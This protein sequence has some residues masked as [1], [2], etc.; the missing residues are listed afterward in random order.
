MSTIC[1][2]GAASDRIDKEYIKD[3]EELGKEMARRGHKMIYGAGSS[4]LMGAAARGMDS[5][6]GHIIGVT[7]HFMHTFEPIYECTTLINTNTMSERKS[8]MEQYGEAFIIVPGGIG[9][10][11]EFFQILTLKELKQTDK[12]I[13]I[14]NVNGYFDKLQELLTDGIQKG[15][16]RKVVPE[17]YYITDNPQKA[18]DIIES[19]LQKNKERN[20]LDQKNKSSQSHDLFD[21]LEM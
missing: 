21:D 3:V 5:K 4:G 11:D 15:F 7:P 17:L 19:E 6:N 16:I 1:L 14:Y 9:T 8:I 18:L 12:P 13:V 2:Y 10:Y 20:D